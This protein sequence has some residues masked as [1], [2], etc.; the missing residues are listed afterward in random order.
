[1]KRILFILLLLCTTTIYLS[2]ETKEE[3]KANPQ[4]L[5]I[6]W[7]DQL[8]ESLMWHNP[9]SIATTM[10]ESYQCTYHEN[11]RH[12]QHIWAE[13]Q[14]RCLSW[15]S[16]GGMVDVS[17]VA[18]DDVT[19]NGKGTEIS[20]DPKHYFY[21]LVIIP[22]VR[23]TYLHH[24]YVNLYSGLGIGLDINGGTEMNA[25]GDKTDFGT[26]IQI[27]VIGLSANYKRWFGAVDL[28]GLTAL[29]DKNTIFM[30]SS[31]MISVSIGARF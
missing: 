18:W 3:R 28:G 21:N 5:R 27:T 23:F 11:F 20:I 7:G 9:T 15:L 6:G 2:A 22:T 24:P 16:F 31:K 1:M 29:K 4:E 13:Y 8:F 25:A 26:A 19:R 30:A 17:E 12:H 10:P 14:W